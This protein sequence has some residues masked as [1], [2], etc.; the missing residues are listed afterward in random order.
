MSMTV[1][2]SVRTRVLPEYQDIVARLRQLMRAC[3]P[4]A[5][6]GIGYGIP[7]F[8]GKRNLAVIRPSKS[9]LPEGPMDCPRCEGA[10]LIPGAWRASRLPGAPVTDAVL[11]LVE[12][13]ASVA[14]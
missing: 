7:V 2:E 9:G 10:S 11:T 6:D 1:D 3:A 4:N 12:L 8:K 14:P 5:K 13:L